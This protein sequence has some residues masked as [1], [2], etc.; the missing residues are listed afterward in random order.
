MR[1]KRSRALPLAEKQRRGT[2]RPCR[3]QKATAKR[4]GSRTDPH[5]HA[6]EYVA[7]V[8]GYVAGVA[9]G[10]I[11]ACRWTKLAVERCARMRSLTMVNK[12]AYRWSPTHVVDICTFVEKLPHVEGK[13]PT[14]TIRLEPFQVFILAAVYGF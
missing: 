13:W 10:S 9:S 8:D 12:C 1:R 7:I 2:V 3:E 4:C 11:V 6:R 5:L 14:P